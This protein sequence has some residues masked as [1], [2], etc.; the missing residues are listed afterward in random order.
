MPKALWTEVCNT[1]WEAAT[2]TIPKRTKCKKP[3]WLS[4]EALQIDEEI[5]EGKSK[6][7]REDIP[8]RIH[9]TNEQFKEVEE[10]KRMG[11][12]RDLFKKLEIS[13]EHFM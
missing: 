5:R 4:E 11:K 12:T 7:E 9:S 3:K 6:G 10:N 13:R 2:K 8:N 1:V